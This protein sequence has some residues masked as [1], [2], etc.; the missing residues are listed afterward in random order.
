MGR[1]GHPQNSQVMLLWMSERSRQIIPLNRSLLLFQPRAG[2]DS[3]CGSIDCSL[4]VAAVRKRTNQR[5]PHDELHACNGVGALRKAAMFSSF[6]SY[7]HLQKWISNY[8]IPWGR[9]YLIWMVGPIIGTN[10]SSQVLNRLAVSDQ[11]EP[12]Y[13]ACPC[14]L[15]T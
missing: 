13:E 6:G 12:I 15:R 14:G 9:C 10:P 7:Q 2:A 3:I 5:K 8:V 1:V 4:F 11:K